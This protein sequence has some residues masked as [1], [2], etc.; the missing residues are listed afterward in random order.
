MTNIYDRAAEVIRTKGH[1]K[2]VF[3]NAV[4]GACCTTG[5]VRR[6]LID[7]DLLDEYIGAMDSA[8]M[9]LVAEAWAALYEPGLIQDNEFT[10][11]DVATW[12]DEDETTA[13]G[14]IAVLEEASRLFEARQ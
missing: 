13:E 9:Q 4:T 1:A 12:N 11:W 10:P 8:E 2:G 3:Q 6:I 14:A 7:D 5:A